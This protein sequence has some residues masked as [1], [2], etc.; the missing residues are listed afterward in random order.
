MYQKEIYS[1]LGIEE[2]SP[3]EKI[4]KTLCNEDELVSWCLSSNFVDARAIDPANFKYI[5]R[6]FIELVVEALGDKEKLL[7]LFKNLIL[8]VGD[9]TYRVMLSL[10]SD[11]FVFNFFE[12]NNKSFW[13]IQRHSTTLGIWFPC[14]A[15]IVWFSQ[16]DSNPYKRVLKSLAIEFFNVVCKNIEKISFSKKKITF[17]LSYNRPHH[18]FVD[19]VR[20][21]YSTI[22]LDDCLENETVFLKEGSFFIINNSKENIFRDK[23]DLNLNSL[24]S[25]F[26]FFSPFAVFLDPRLD[27]E[28]EEWIAEQ[29]CEKYGLLSKELP[30]D[31]YVIWLSICVEKRSWV[32]MEEGVK[33]IIKSY[34]E[35]KG[36]LCVILDGITSWEE[37]DRESYIKNFGLI[38][39]EFA[40]KI[41]LLFPDIKIINTVGFNAKEKIS[42]AI[43]TDFF[44]TNFLTD[45][46]YVARF[47]RKPGVGYGANSADY[48]LQSHPRTFMLPGKYVQESGKEEN[49]TRQGFHIEP[50]D[51]IIFSKKIENLQKSIRVDGSIFS[52]KG[53]DFFDNKDGSCILKTNVDSHVYVCL[54]EKYASAAKR[55]EKSHLV[56]IGER[57]RFRFESVSKEGAILYVIG[58]K[59]GERFSTDRV[60]SGNSK[61]IVFQDGVSH[62]RLLLRLPMNEE[63][64]FY[65]VFWV[66]RKSSS[67]AWFTVE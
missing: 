20:A 31:C 26:S 56:E 17:L 49:W 25:G 46:M 33:K 22:K 14:E 51:L 47:A 62:F 37:V 42:L 7:F 65:N 9:N 64:V 21:Y 8:P 10:A 32:E 41:K 38:D 58:Y 29:S 48:S 27:R 59:D 34:K 2:D 60:K 43:K 5:S 44:I 53:F 16:I 67:S 39:Y 55:T 30:E 61:D 50:N 19:L 35:E 24:L 40:E 11:N 45:S 28:Y 23:N 66:T 4:K 6:D 13:L 63:L 36:P 57:Y 15:K 3:L 18:F 52:G 1:C 12:N 54:N